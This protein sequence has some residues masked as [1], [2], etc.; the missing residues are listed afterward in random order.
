MGNKKKPS[1]LERGSND[2]MKAALCIFLMETRNI[3]K[4]MISANVGS[5]SPVKLAINNWGEVILAQKPASETIGPR[6][7]RA[8]MIKNPAA[9]E[10]QTLNMHTP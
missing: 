9:K 5:V 8:I 7:L 6:D 10:Q 2:Q 1:V 4:A 3:P